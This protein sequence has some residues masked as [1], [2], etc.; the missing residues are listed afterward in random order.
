MEA[1]CR[2]CAPGSVRCDQHLRTNERCVLLQTD[3]KDLRLSIALGPS[4]IALILFLGINKGIVPYLNLTK[5]L[6][7]EIPSLGCILPNFDGVALRELDVNLTIANLSA[8]G[9]DP[10][11]E[12]DQSIVSLLN[13]ALEFVGKTWGEVAAE[14]ARGLIGLSVMYTANQGI[15]S[16]LAEAKLNHSTCNISIGDPDTFVEATTPIWI[17]CGGVAIILAIAAFFVHRRETKRT[18][19]SSD[20]SQ[21]LQ[22]WDGPQSPLLQSD[23][24]TVAL[25]PGHTGFKPAPGQTFSCYPCVAF[26]STTPWWVVPIVIV[27]LAGNAVLFGAAN[28]GVG[29]S[30][31]MRLT[32]QEEPTMLPSIAQFGLSDSIHDMWV[33]KVYALAF[34]IGIWSG[35][36]PYVKIVLLGFAF[37]SPFTFMN[38]AHGEKLLIAVDTLG[39]WALID[40]YV[41]VLMMV[42]FRLDLAIG[43]PGTESY[44]AFDILVSPYFG[45]YGFIFAGMVSLATSSILLDLHRRATRPHPIDNNHEK[46]ALFSYPAAT[47]ISKKFMW[48]LFGGSTTSRILMAGGLVVTFILIAVGCY[49]DSFTFH[50]KGLAGFAVG[51]EGEADN[52]YSVI[53]LSLAV[54]NSSKDPSDFRVHFIEVHLLP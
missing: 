53:S 9:G 28:R 30:I 31:E 17:S 47:P 10:A 52:S 22:N 19:S 2:R 7:T 33:A 1:A 27:V 42:A 32:L 37:F 26:S 14:A 25:A 39:K 50:F 20:A 16:A 40:A 44:A 24:G 29:A 11:S 41:L 35:A 18:I 21:S 43:K 46:R 51:L 6:D 54:P 36:W 8:L 12:L 3:P 45:F 23:A 48:Y 5:L 38:P 4:N 34:L 49:V 13:L 15:S